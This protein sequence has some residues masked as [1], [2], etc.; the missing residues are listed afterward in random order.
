[1]KKLFFKTSYDADSK[2]LF[3]VFGGTYVPEM[4][5]PALDELSRAYEEAK[6]DP[7][8]EKELLQIYKDYVGR[9]SALYYA[10]NLTK[11]LG[12][13]KIYIKNEGLN[14][15]GAHKIN[16]CVGQALL[17]KRMGKKRINKKKKTK[18]KKK[19]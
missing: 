16:H 11:K 15:T 14:H 13:A 9:P 2:G 17:A 8:F 6:V 7:A 4:L 10:E 1:M 19:T 5:I 18:T 12:G 3:G